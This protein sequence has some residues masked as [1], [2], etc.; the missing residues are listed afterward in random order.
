MTVPRL[1]LYGVFP[2]G[3]RGSLYLSTPKYKLHVQ[4]LELQLSLFEICNVVDL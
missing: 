4:F 3:V 1:L 2:I